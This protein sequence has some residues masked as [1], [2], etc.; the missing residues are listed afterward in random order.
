MADA[1]I[2]LEAETGLDIEVPESWALHRE[3]RAGDSTGRL[4]RRQAKPG[5]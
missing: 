5:A 1:W 4:Y 2:F 3:V